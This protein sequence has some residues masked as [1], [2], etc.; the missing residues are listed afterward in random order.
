MTTPNASPSAP[1][2]VL[3]SQP[4]VAP[5]LMPA[6]GGIWRLT[7]RRV[8]APNRAIMAIVLLGALGLLTFRFASR[9]ST[10]EYF[11][12]INGFVMGATLS[13]LAFLGGAGAV[14]ESLK[15]GSVDYLST[16]PVPRPLHVLFGYLSQ[17]AC[18]LIAGLGLIGFLYAVGSF[19]GAANLAAELPRQ[20][21]LM[22][23]GVVAF[24][25]LGYGMGALT[26]RYMI[27]GLL[28]A[29]VIEAGLGNIPIQINKLSISRH[30]HLL[31]DGAGL[32]ALSWNATTLGALGTL[33]LIATV[34]VGVAMAVF[35]RMEFM[36][37]KEKD[38]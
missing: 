33:L 23:A 32:R 19:G 35:A 3:T 25:A 37:S 29:G 10:G 9:S 12:W 14:R 24:T 11:D 2:S 36:G 28:Y 18:G 15:P 7:W 8:F 21:V 4:R 6:L 31:Q 20:V 16:R 13:I 22:S 27:L 30:I 34:L 5:R 17:T 26:N 38:A 1:N